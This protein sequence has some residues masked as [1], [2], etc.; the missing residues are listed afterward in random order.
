MIRLSRRLAAPPVLT[1][2]L[3]LGAF[4][5]S[6]WLRA[7]FPIMAL[8]HAIYD[9]QLFVKLAASL[10]SGEWLGAYDNLT[11]AKGAAYSMFLWL[12]DVSGLHLKTAEHV[13]YLAAAL[14]FS[15][16]AGVVFR[17]RA[18]MAGCFIVLA[19]N[20]VFWAP[21]VGGRVVREDLYVSLSLLLLAL[22]VRVFLIEVSE[23]LAED[24]RA[25][26]STLVALGVVGA[27]YW[28]T[29]EEGV[30]LLPAVLLLAAYWIFT[31]A[32]HVAG[33]A[34]RHWARAVAFAAIPIASFAFV[35]G[36][37]DAVNFAKYG[38][39]RNNDFRS[40]DFQSGYGALARIDHENWKRFVVFPED[41]R[42]KA[43]A[44]SPAARE[45]APYFEGAGGEFW[46]K[47]S[48]EQTGA[49][50]CPEILSGWFM[51]ALREAVASA[52]HYRNAVAARDYYLRLARE[53]DQA[54]DA[55]VIACRRRS[56]SL[57]P[58]W[59][60]EYFGW[61][62]SAARTV[63]S[64]LVSLG[65]VQVNIAP[66][67]GPEHQLRLF[68]DVTNGPLAEATA[69]GRA[70]TRVAV[71]RTLAAIEIDFFRFAIPLAMLAWVGMLTT[72][73]LRKR[74][75]PAYILV[76]ALI[77]AIAARTLLLAFLEATSIPSNNALY[78][79]PV[80][81]MALALVPCVL[82]LLLV[83]GRRAE[84]S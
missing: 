29:R 52:G 82:A 74:W 15:A 36:A 21:D 30:W 45:L 56:D 41:A 47:V 67:V 17:S 57:V 9:D 81:P 12:V 66:S 20:P 8:G 59:R 50:S 54:C 64:T 32:R 3:I 46:R 23:S 33:E 80:V 78:L 18:A 77:V 31:K 72:A 61:T 26:R 14:Y 42:R 63:F 25:K 69:G 11:L 76:A 68:N 39:F 43:Y 75:H 19:F 65:R 55:G 5:F 35:V 27:I 60:A 58:P 6:L 73:I 24:L 79:S 37:V 13:V 28:L 7:A 2:A 40:A 38:V 62:L 22:C 48:C 83:R 4:A 53:V 44:V 70:G 1:W 34:R 71:A 49:A 84:K 16:T 51:W 10:G